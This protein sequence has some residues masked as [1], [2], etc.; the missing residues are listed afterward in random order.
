[1]VS[2]DHEICDCGIR[3][4]QK[5]VDIC[6]GGKKYKNMYWNFKL[7]VE[8]LELKISVHLAERFEG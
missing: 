4:F 2:H 6:R 7:T 3:N 8:C 1:M 5:F